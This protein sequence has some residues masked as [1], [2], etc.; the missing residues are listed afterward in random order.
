MQ[1]NAEVFDNQKGHLL[2]YNTLP[3]IFLPHASTRAQ[4]PTA[5]LKIH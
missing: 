4:E 3:T 1:L 2:K 5:F